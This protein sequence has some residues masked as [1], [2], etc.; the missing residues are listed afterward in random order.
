[1]V[2]SR[3]CD[4]IFKPEN[5]LLSEALILN[6]TS[7][8]CK[9][10]AETLKKLKERSTCLKKEKILALILAKRFEFLQHPKL[11]KNIILP[12]SGSKTITNFIDKVLKDKFEQ[13]LKLNAVIAAKIDSNNAPVRNSTA[14]PLIYNDLDQFV[15]AI[16]STR[17]N[18]FQ[19]INDDWKQCYLDKPGGLKK[20]TG[21]DNFLALW[22]CL[23]FDLEVGVANLDDISWYATLVLNL[24]MHNASYRPPV[25]GYGK[26]QQREMDCPN[27]YFRSQNKHSVSRLF[28]ALT[29]DNK[30]EQC[31]LP[32]NEDTFQ[33]LRQN[34]TDFTLNLAKYDVYGYVMPNQQV[35]AAYFSL[36]LAYSGLRSNI[37][38]V[39]AIAIDFFLSSQTPLLLVEKINKEL[40]IPANQKY[41]KFSPWVLQERI[42]NAQEVVRLMPTLKNEPYYPNLYADLT[43]HRHDTARQLIQLSDA[44]KF[45]RIHVAWDSETTCLE[46]TFYNGKAEDS[47]NYSEGVTNVIINFFVALLNHYLKLAGFFIHV[48]RRQSFGFNRITITNTTNMCMRVSLGY[49]PV[50]FNPIFLKALSSLDVILDQNNFLDKTT[51]TLKEGFKVVEKPRKGEITDKT[52]IQFLKFMR[53]KGKSL[54][55]INVAQNALE[56]A[57]KEVGY[58]QQAFCQYINFIASKDPKLPELLPSLTVIGQMKR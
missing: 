25:K 10:L 28:K 7:D 21:Q 24:Y 38:V 54:A 55:S 34:T 19:Q 23:I 13:A 51:E 6:I 37:Y 39:T 42:V 22:S 52:G 45:K 4:D 8:D 44:A 36:P 29:T 31:L 49:E 18:P 41:L 11:I 35:N 43:N 9:T 50:S 58:E 53:A 48:D 32:R 5:R 46:I 30:A 17:D 40:F 20:K 47:E 16:K 3:L 15:K 56:Q 12:A 1:M 33:L 14:Y 57:P 26:A 2:L 27:L